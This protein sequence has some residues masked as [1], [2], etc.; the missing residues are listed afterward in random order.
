MVETFTADHKE[1]NKMSRYICY[2]TGQIMSKEEWRSYYA[3]EIDHKEYADF[4][5]W[6]S[7]MIKNVLE[8]EKAND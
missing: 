5:I 4:D 2:E 7:D 8:G 3:T 1:V 6:W